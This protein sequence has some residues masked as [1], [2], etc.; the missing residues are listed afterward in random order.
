MPHRYRY[1]IRGLWTLFV[2]VAA[3]K[4]GLTKLLRVLAPQVTVLNFLSSFSQRK[5]ADHEI[6]GLAGTCVSLGSRRTLRIG[7]TLL[8]L[9]PYTLAWGRYHVILYGIDS[10]IIA[11][12]IEHA[13]TE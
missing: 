11:I 13:G 10:N 7:V 6:T 12:Y 4:D 3:N 1:A 5:Q 2:S 8:A 9:D